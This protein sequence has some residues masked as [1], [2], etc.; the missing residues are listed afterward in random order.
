MS[1]DAG[2][3]LV[4]LDELQYIACQ[5]NNDVECITKSFER[6]IVGE[7]SLGSKSLLGSVLLWLFAAWNGTGCV[8]QGCCSVQVSQWICRYGEVIVP[9]RYPVSLLLEQ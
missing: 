4:E 7:M 2:R 1:I 9:K 8:A 5:M 3:R 6:I